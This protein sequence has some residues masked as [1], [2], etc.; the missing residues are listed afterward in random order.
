[1]AFSG[2]IDAQLNEAHGKSN[3]KIRGFKRKIKKWNKTKNH[4]LT[5]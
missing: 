2:F 1:M 3:D 5:N 4:L